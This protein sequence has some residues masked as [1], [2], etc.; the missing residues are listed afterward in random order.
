MLNAIAGVGMISVG[1]IGNPAIGTVQDM[2][3]A[4][5]I[6]AADPALAPRVIV[7]RPGLFGESFAI[8]P[9][10]RAQVTDPRSRRC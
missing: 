9:A 7:E 3:F 4:T 6:R 2:A 8:D 5:E 1:T 10:K